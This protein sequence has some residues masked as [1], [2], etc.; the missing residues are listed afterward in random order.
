MEGKKMK[1]KLLALLTAGILM[2]VM[3][4]SANATIFELSAG[5]SFFDSSTQT[6][7]NLTGSIT[8]EFIDFS[9]HPAY[10]VNNWTYVRQNIIAMNINGATV[11]FTESVW[12]WGHGGGVIDITDQGNPLSVCQ[13]SLVLQDG[14]TFIPQ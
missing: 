12:P 6:Y 1:K 5:S 10:A 3:L 11:N 2:V 4:G 13:V 8:T 9:S 14:T 7:Q